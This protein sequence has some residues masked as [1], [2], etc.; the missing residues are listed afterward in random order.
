MTLFVTSQDQAMRFLLIIQY[1]LSFFW[2]SNAEKQYITWGTCGSF[3]SSFNYD[4]SMTMDC[5][6]L[7]FPLNRNEP[8]LGYVNAFLRR[9]YVSKPTNN[10]IWFVAGGPGDS[11]VTMVPMANY[12]VGLNRTWTA[13]LL[14][15]RGTGLSSAPTCSHPP[16]GHFNP[17]NNSLIEIYEKCN[18]ELIKKYGNISK[19][20][21]TYDGAMDFLETIQS[22]NPDNISIYAQ[23]YGT[24][25]TN[26]FMQLPGAR[27]DCVLFDGPIPGNRWPMENNAEWCS[28]VTANVA[29]GCASDSSVCTSSI[30]EMGHL[31]RLVMDAIIDGT[32]PCLQKLPWLNTEAG[33][34]WVR[35]YANYFT[36]GTTVKSGLAPFWYRLYRCSPTDIEQLN[37]F[38]NYRQANEYYSQNQLIL[39]YGLAI[40]I[41]ASEIYSFAGENA[42]SYEQQ[43]FISN[44]LLADATPQFVISY[45]RDISNFPLFTPNTTFYKKIA[46]PT[47][48]VLILVG[49][50][51]TNTENGLGLWLRNGFG[52]HAN[53]VNFPYGCHG[54][55]SPDY[56]CALDIAFTFFNSSGQSYDASCIASVAAPDWDGN[57]T[58]TQSWSKKN[59]NTTDLWNNGHL[60]DV[61][62]ASTCECNTETLAPSSEEKTYSHNTVK[63]MITAIVCGITIPLVLIMTGLILYIMMLRKNQ[64]T[65]IVGE[66]NTT[67]LLSKSSL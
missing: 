65:E 24:Y 47:Y 17:Y 49:T 40:I 16:P 48:P 45:G 13:Y 51:D 35:V 60:R 18:S 22:V 6:N 55:V 11:T 9:L 38:N 58:A 50:Y 25:F 67:N 23:S 14:D 61:K 34:F 37:Y 44:R 66:S 36:A 4:S 52:K 29:Y 19:Y 39:S 54:L 64:H 31:P 3:Q 63:Q 8:A 20:Y 5:A 21:S 42:L 62:S 12:F 30:G 56:P 46:E 27:A 57:E 2:L 15:Q 26:T 32:L 59:F 7:T 41:G 1:Y 53:L 10:S 28:E 33:A 43:V